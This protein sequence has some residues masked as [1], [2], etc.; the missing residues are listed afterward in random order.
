MP[1]RTAPA[2]LSTMPSGIPHIIGN[3]LAERFSFYGMKAILVAFMTG[4][5]VDGAGR[6]DHLPEAQASEWFHYFVFAVYLT[7]LLGGLLADLWLGKYRTII[8][9]SLVYCLG[10]LALAL[11]D[12]RLGLLLGLGLIALG[13]GGIKPCVSAHVGDQFATTNAHLLPRVYYWFYLSINIGSFISMLLTPWLLEQ[14]GAHVAFAIPGVLMVVATVVFWMGR[15]RF[16][17]IPPDRAGFAADLRRPEV[18]RSIL[19]LLGIYA[20]VAMFWSLFDQTHSRWVLQAEHMD[21]RIFGIELLP[22]QL[23]SANPLLVLILVPVF[24]IFVYPLVDRFIRVTP[25]RKIGAGFCL[26]VLSF[27]IPAWV[28]TWIAAGQTPGIG[29]QVL[30]YVLITAAEVLISIT[31]LEFSYTQAPPRLK[32]LIMGLYLAS[33]ALGNLFTAL[34]NGWIHQAGETASLSGAAYYWF[35]VKMMAATTAVFFIVSLFYK[36]RTYIQGAPADVSE[37]PGV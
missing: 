16:A 33:V 34:V 29:W 9:L 1:Y 19:A 31:C 23:Q 37:A 17:H 11:D 14:Y 13:S 2:P 30:A 5:M 32:S 36:G 8:L 35:F 7:P 15:H 4:A 27:M 10:H 26:A 22:S 18:L 28:E 12:T 3:E 20:L 24:S 21:R 6:A 25:L